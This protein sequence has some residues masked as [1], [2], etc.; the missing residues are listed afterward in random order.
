M[1][2][3]LQVEILRD[4]RGAANIVPE[5]L[6]LWDRCCNVTPFQRPEWL[7]TWMEIF[8]PEDARIVLIRHDGVLVGFAP[9]LIFQNGSDRVL[10]LMGGGISD[11][12]DVLI[13]PQCDEEILEKLWDRTNEEGNWAA[14]SLSDLSHNSPLLRWQP[15]H[16]SAVVHD[17]CPVLQLPSS[18]EDLRSVVPGEQLRNLRNARAR[19]NRAGGGTID[20]A[21]P[22]TV[23][24]TLEEIFRLHAAR[25]SQSGQQGVL[26]E[27]Q[28][29]DFHRKAA[30]RLLRAG[31]LGLYSL[32]HQGQTIATLYALYAREKV[33]CYL[34]GFDP[35]CSFF[36]P[37]TLI[38]GAAL[39]GAI[40]RKKSS[41]DFL[42]GAESY[43]YKW[44]ATD[45][46]TYRIQ[47]RRSFPA[48]QASLQRVA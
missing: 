10:G 41:A 33:Y 23:Q 3:H 19:L 14:A 21:N 7:F 32:R 35:E 18:P 40:L 12:L 16:S 37:G 9:F 8:Q 39:E 30:G 25:W 1:K 47:S 31:M 44:G 11:Y 42:R 26:C 28:V 38:L 29:Q 5:W 36:S 20:V 48:H 17:V 27:A 34:Q 13:A 24:A 22:S 6:Q 43:K 46:V 15:P 2:N 4:W 45:Q